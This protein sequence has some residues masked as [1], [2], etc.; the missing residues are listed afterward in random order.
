[1]TRSATTRPRTKQSTTIQSI[2]FPKITS[3]NNTNSVDIINHNFTMISENAGEC[4]ML[5]HLMK[6]IFQR[7]FLSRLFIH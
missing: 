6:Y 4:L 7:F 3:Y 2:I 1:M 5:D